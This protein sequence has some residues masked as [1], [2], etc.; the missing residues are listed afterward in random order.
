MIKLPGK[1][2]KLRSKA[3]ECRY[4]LPFGAELAASLDDN[5]PHRSTVNAL[6]HYLLEVA[7]CLSSAPYAAEAA[8]VACRKF[9]ILYVTLEKESLA[10][11]DEYSWKCK[12]KLHMFQELIEFQ[13]PDHGNPR[14]FW[15]YL[16]E[17]WG[18]FLSRAASRRGGPKYGPT[19]AQ[20]LLD[21]FRALAT[22]EMADKNVE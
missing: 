20:G 11:G 13:A 12:P 18:G 16:D 9:C 8:S 2:P 6:M 21:R 7:M 3:G 14:L 1:T 10:A 17:S 5:T 22:T 4:L 15:T 19:V